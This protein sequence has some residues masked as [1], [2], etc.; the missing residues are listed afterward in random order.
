[1]AFVD[2][3]DV[4]GPLFKYETNDTL[5]RP[6]DY[7][8]YFYG[9][10]LGDG[11]AMSRAPYNEVSRT[12][13]HF[14]FVTELYADEFDDILVSAVQ[15][16]DKYVKD[17]HVALDSVEYAGGPR[18]YRYSRSLEMQILKTGCT[19]SIDGQGV[20][21]GVLGGKYFINSRL[22][23]TCKAVANATKPYVRPA[24]TSFPPRMNRESVRIELPSTL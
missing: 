6:G 11:R 3:V 24:F 16:G 10:E 4:L 17:P 7:I 8:T 2:L 1:M 13:A 14:A 20:L 12:G 22:R 23:A 21:V 9:G 18:T 19:T 15:I 5:P